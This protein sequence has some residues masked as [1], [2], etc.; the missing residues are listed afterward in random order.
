MRVLMVSKACVVGTYQKK[1]EE[2]AA[3]PNV[4]LIV[5]VPPYWKE[6]GRTILLERQHTT[7][8]T[9]ATEPM[10]L[11][12]H[13]HIHFFP[14]LERRVRSTRPDIVHIEEEAY[15]LSTYLAVR[16]AR[17]SGA[18]TTLFSWQNTLR[19]YPP[20]FSWMETYVLQNV[21][22][23]IAGNT[24]AV[25]VLRAKEYRGPVTVIPQFG[26]DPEVFRS[27]PEVRSSRPAGCFTIGYAGRLVEQKGVDLLLQAA[28]KLPCDW[29]LRLLGAGPLRPLLLRLADELGV[30][31]RVTLESPIP[32]RRMP[33]FLNSLDVLA[34]PSV[35]RRNW[36]EQFGRVLVEAMACEI[37]VI[38]SDSGEIPNVIGDSGLLF[39]EGECEALQGQLVSLANCRE[40]R[41]ALATQGRE[42][43]MARFTQ[44]R[45]AAKTYQVYEALA[46]RRSQRYV[47]ERRRVV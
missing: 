37:P 36:K 34:L 23:S 29:H 2:L 8:Y 6:S 35:T 25:N 42:R 47:E 41:D 27:M 43:V 19:R 9:L 40:L 31:S 11:N 5:V 33:F 46:R 39:P 20:P 12:G 21:D 26:V 3:F 28:A 22:H 18:Q 10:V 32:S 38:G 1:L 14:G 45:I 16:S 4:E 17:R 15:N 13:F 24:E 30:G 7:G 44:A